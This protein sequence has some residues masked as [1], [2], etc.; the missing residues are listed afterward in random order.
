LGKALTL[1][2]VSGHPAGAET[3]RAESLV[4]HYDT[5]VDSVVS[6]TTVVDVS[7]NGINGTLTNGAAYSSTDRAFTFDGTNDRITATLNN[8]S[9]AWVHSIS[10]WMKPSAISRVAF[11]I[12]ADNAN[13]TSTTI[14]FGV[15]GTF[16]NYY[17]YSN[18]KLFTYTPSVNQLY[19]IVM[20][21]DGGSTISSRR[22]WVNGTELTTYTTGGT[23]GALNL[24]ANAPLYIGFRKYGNQPFDGQISNFKVWGGVA[25]TAEEVAAEYALG[26]TGKSLN[27]TD[28]ALCLGGTV[29]RAQLDVRG[30]AMIDS[31]LVIKYKNSLEYARDGGIMLSRAGL[32]NV[33]NK[34]SSQP[35]VLDGGDSTAIDG[36]IR[37]GAMWS[38]WGGAQYGIAMRGASSNDTYPYL[39]DPTLFVTN[40]KIGIGTTSPAYTLDVNGLAS[41]KTRRVFEFSGSDNYARHFWLCSFLD[42]PGYHTNQL[43]KINY[44]VTYK[45]LTG[46]HSRNSLA[47]GT[48]TLSNLWRF[49]TNGTGGDEQ[50]VTLQD[51]K[52][53]QY[54]GFGKLP[55]W[56]YVRCNN[57]GYLVL[58]TSISSGDG[59]SYYV[60]G[61]VEFLT[62]PSAEGA[63]Y[64]WNGTVYNDNNIAE[65]EGFTSISNLYP[66]TGTSEVGWDATM[67]SEST[68]QNFIEATEGTVFKYGNVGIGTTS[69]AYTLDVSGTVNTGAL[70]AT[71]GTFTGAVTTPYINGIGYVAE[72]TYT[73]NPTNNTSKY[74]LGWTSEN[75]LDIEIYHSGF[76]HGGSARFRVE[77]K[78]SSSTPPVITSSDLDPGG[79]FKLYY[80]HKN[81]RFYVWFNETLTSSDNNVTYQV[82]MKTVGK[83]INLTEP[84]S[85]EVYGGDV[86]GV[87]AASEFTNRGLV[88]KP[89]GAGDC[90]VGIGTTSP[91]YKLDVNGTVNTGALTATSA[92][93][94][95]DGD[96]VMGGKPLKPAG[97]LHWDRVNSRLG[98][99][100]TSPAATLDVNGGVR[101]RLPHMWMRQTA[102]PANTTSLLL[103]WNS[104]VY[105]DTTL[106]NM[107]SSTR[108]CNFPIKGVYV[109]TIQ[110]HTYWAGGADYNSKLQWEQK[111]SSGGIRWTTR[112]NPIVDSI[113]SGNSDVHQT[114]TMVIMAEAGDYLDVSHD[115]SITTS[116][117]YNGGW[118]NIRAACIYAI[119]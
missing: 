14:G 26:R 3:P 45:R 64:V 42:A 19:H 36:N 96:F 31:G 41:S 28:T 117:N 51:Q 40:D 18:D 69:P 84:T 43:I 98:V 70:T 46:T 67:T 32:G 29:P 62:R 58:C 33:T 50:F 53:E 52:N 80:T 112:D 85:T 47:S 101:T 13:P 9:G 37:G 49:S 118:N 27:L 6:G 99:G 66:T 38:Q 108:T 72:R 110:T 74:F 115:T 39:Q 57:R 107:Y 24:G 60:K 111:N 76:N 77:Y 83:P 79:V 93:V 90:Y 15:D 109:V 88:T 86:I 21:Y 102:Q 97:G 71:S 104:T 10:F 55:K 2:R 44:S 35:I 113:N 119:N 5:T 20:T 75:A 34:Y 25:L 114:G 73:F 92:T 8:P 54:T 22:M 78:W 103:V 91:A 17:F 81:D 94:P 87:S 12:G 16:L 23:I 106:G 89:V 4:V 56:Y 11:T 116:R 1:P 59:S 65:T 61:N 7:G 68:A 100:T 30:G 48:V 105:N 95:N 63:D 82:R